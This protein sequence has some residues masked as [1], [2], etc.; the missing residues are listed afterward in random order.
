MICV[1]E[2]SCWDDI[3]YQT[4]DKATRSPEISRGQVQKLTPQFLLYIYIGYR[5][6]LSLIYYLGK[7]HVKI[8]YMY[9]YD[10]E[11]PPPPI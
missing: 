10:L 11:K 4:L 8:P 6:P 7:L 2:W 1:S 5:F 3:W 9:I